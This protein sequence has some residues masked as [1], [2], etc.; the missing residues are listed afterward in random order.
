ML[1][2]HQHE[3]HA[4]PDESQGDGKRL[5]RSEIRVLHKPAVTAG[6]A[7]LRRANTALRR[8]ACGSFDSHALESSRL[9]SSSLRATGEQLA[10]HLHALPGSHHLAENTAGN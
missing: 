4:A 3:D 9:Q 5:G 6:S 2:C 7:R 1:C 8:W 10:Q